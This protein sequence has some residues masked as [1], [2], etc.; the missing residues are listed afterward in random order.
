[1]FDS[2]GLCLRSSELPRIPGTKL[3]MSLCRSHFCSVPFCVPGLR[4]V[5]MDAHTTAAARAVAL[6]VCQANDSAA[7]ENVRLRR[8]VERA[9]LAIEQ[10][11]RPLALRR[12]AEALG[13]EPARGCCA[14]CCA[15]RARARLRFVRRP[16]AHRGANERHRPLA[17]PAAAAAAAV[18]AVLPHAAVSASSSKKSAIMR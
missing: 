18:H 10:G 6:L 4:C 9:R 7:E 3:W 17:G 15:A 11:N 5:T 13:Q 16:Q 8:A 14:G 2:G 12:L 1:M